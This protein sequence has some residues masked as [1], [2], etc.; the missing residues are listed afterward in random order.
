MAK[1]KRGRQKRRPQGRPR[2]IPMRMDGFLQPSDLAGV[3]PKLAQAILGVDWSGTE[4]DQFVQMV[5][6][7]MPEIDA[8]HR[9]DVLDELLVLAAD[10]GLVLAPEIVEVLHHQC[11]Q[12][13]AGWTVQ[14]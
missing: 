12:G 8:S 11:D 2:A 6:R 14:A 1:S 3:S 10:D 7:V 4:P 9:H 13:G 5:Q